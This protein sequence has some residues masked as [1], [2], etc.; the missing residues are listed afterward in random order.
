MLRPMP[1]RVKARKAASKATKSRPRT[2]RL[3]HDDER[4]VDEQEHKDGFSGVVA[5]AV[6]FYRE[7]I[8]VQRRKLLEA[9]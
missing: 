8:D 3:P 6:R 1:R 9:V 2:I 7:H 4:W 5:D